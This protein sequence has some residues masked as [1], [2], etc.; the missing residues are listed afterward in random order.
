MIALVALYRPGPLGSGMIDNFVAA[1]HG[2][3]KPV[4][5]LP[6]MKDILEETYGLMVYQEQVMQV[7]RAVAGFSLGESEL[8]RKA[9]AKK[10]GKQMEKYQ[11]Q[12]I[13]RAAARN[14][15]KAVAAR[16]MEQITHFAEY[17][18]NKSHSAA[19][20][21]LSYRTAYLK[22]HHPLEFMAALMTLEVDNSD[23]IMARCHECKQVGIE[24]LPPEINSSQREFGVEKGRLTFGLAGVK[25]VGKGAIDAILEAR[26]NTGGFESLH[27]FCEETDMRRVNR[28]VVESLIKAGAFDSATGSRSRAFA[29]LDAALEAAAIFQ[30]DRSTGQTNMFGELDAPGM[31]QGAGENLPQVPEWDDQTRMDYEKEA[32]G[33]YFTRHPLE[34]FSKEIKRFA[35]HDA[36]SLQEVTSRRNVVISGVITNRKTMET[37]AG[38][39]M[40]F[41]ELQDLKG[42]IEVTCFPK[43]FEASGD[44]IQTEKPVLIRGVTESDEKDA[45]VI[46]NEIILLENTMREWSHQVHLTV[47]AVGLTRE[48]LEELKGIVGRFPGK[49]AGYIHV[50]SP[51]N[52]EAVVRMHE[53]QGIDP[54]EVFIEEVE[55]LLGRGTVFLE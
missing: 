55:N 5:E 33:F 12:F 49:C 29:G 37:K 18:F 17:G 13:E 16:I 20:A 26:E 45:K 9:I 10:Q 53:G 42:V 23:K 21:V 19:Y 31:R 47:Q 1:K 15:D 41:L 8:L 51:E 54:S 43:T 35:T 25:N 11:R 52:W 2:E 14:I 39:R 30:R 4:Y 44:L 24:I 32:L 3:I 40:A 27:H 38:K 28:R 6:V 48:R 22:A 46:A 36:L 34:D 7:V 50:T